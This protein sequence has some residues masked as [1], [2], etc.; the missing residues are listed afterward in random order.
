MKL[1]L[2]YGDLGLNI[3]ERYKKDVTDVTYTR[4]LAYHAAARLGKTYGHPEV[5]DEVRGLL[6]PYIKGEIERVGGAYGPTV[7]RFGGNAT[8]FMLDRGFMP[9]AKESQIMSAEKLIAEQPRDPDGLYEMPNRGF[10][11][12]IWIDTV[13]GVCPFLVWM[14]RVANE[15]KYL[16]EAV[17]QM[18][19]HH[20]RLFDP[21]VKLY[22]QAY[23]AKG[24]N[25]L[26]P[27]H[28]SRGEGW[29][30]LAL[31]EMLYDVPRIAPNH[32]AIPELLKEYRD[33]L[34]G[35]AATQDPSGL[36]HQ[37]MEDPGSYLETSG[38]GLILYAIG[39]GLKNGSIAKEDFD[40]F[41]SIYLKGLKGMMG[42]IA[43]DGTIYH[44]C[45]GCLAPGYNGTAADYALHQWIRNDSHAFG[46]QLLNLSQAVSLEQK[47]IIPSLEKLMEN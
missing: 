35:C 40:R 7:Y 27:S 31:A 36:W 23:N 4:I 3:W 24:T 21:A 43:M 6:Q 30:L 11:G 19:G 29:G 16:E 39:R 10:H 9:E 18:V 44:C 26:T 12:F 5:I 17:K 41:R 1:G 22:F 42:Y 38:T 14:S 2:T 32:P 15:P 25:K 8:A 34:E 46:P 20:R 37:A 45:K 13:F 33:N 28:W 47:G